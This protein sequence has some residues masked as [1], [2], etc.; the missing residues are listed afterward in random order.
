VAGTSKAIT[1]SSIDKK[2]AYKYV[3][4]KNWKKRNN[5]IDS[6]IYEAQQNLKNA[7]PNKKQQFEQQIEV[8]KLQKENHLNNLEKAFDNLSKAE[9]NKYAKNIGIIDNAFSEIDNNRYTRNQQIEA[10]K[11]SDA[12]MQENED[13]VG[14]EN[15]DFEVEKSIGDALK[16]TENDLKIALSEAAAINIQN[17]DLEII[18]LSSNE[19]AKIGLQD[20]DAAFLSK[21]KAKKR[22]I[23]DKAVIL[24]NTEL[25]KETGQTNVIGHELLHYMMSKYFKTDNDSLKEIVGSFKDYV[26]KVDKENNT[27]ILKRIEQRITDNYKDSKG[28]IRAGGRKN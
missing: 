14:K 25:A 7:T 23:G 12:A 13:L 5:E 10:K 18:K 6:Y 2:N 15:Y 22:G 9:L 17:K 8:L 4:P 3:A 20:K 1:L 24:I 27:N 16:K 26:A 21:E 19:A 28:N 11:R